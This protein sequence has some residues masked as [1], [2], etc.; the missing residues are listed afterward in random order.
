MAEIVKEGKPASKRYQRNVWVKQCFVTI[1]VSL[2]ALCVLFIPLS[3]NGGPTALST[4]PII[5][6]GSYLELQKYI[7]GGLSALAGLDSTMTD[8][9]G[10]IL[11]YSIYAFIGIL[12]LDI[13]F[14]LFLILTKSVIARVFFK[15]LSIIF[16]I[17]FVGIALAQLVQILGYVG[18]TLHDIS[19]EVKMCPQIDAFV[20]AISVLIVS[21]V[22]VNRQKNWFARWY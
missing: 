5:G 8:L 20:F 4:M 18:W 3:F 13:V 15:I 21:I 7:A 12:A 16:A 9:I 2:I 14:A 10:M 11:N 19:S 22:M 6:D 1:I 17:A